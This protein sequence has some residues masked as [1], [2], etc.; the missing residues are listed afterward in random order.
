MRSNFRPTHTHTSI[1][2]HTRAITV[3]GLKCFTHA[4]LGSYRQIFVACCAAHAAWVYEGVWVCVC[5]CMCMRV[6]VHASFVYLICHKIV[7][8][9][10]L[11]QQ[12]QEQQYTFK[13]SPKKTELENAVKANQKLFRLRNASQ[14]GKQP[15]AKWQHRCSTC[16]PLLGH[17]YIRLMEL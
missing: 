15:K 2:M 13:S 6:E 10:Q 16:Y 17:G 1:H 3:T 9:T 11:Q 7:F 4:S 12:Q 5:V 8:H 14:T